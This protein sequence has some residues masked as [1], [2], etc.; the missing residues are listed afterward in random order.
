MCECSERLRAAERER[1][2]LR[3]EVE[4]LKAGRSGSEREVRSA[5]DAAHYAH[6]D[7]AQARREERERC[8]MACEAQAGEVRGARW[9]AAAIRALA[10][11]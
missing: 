5:Q 1:D 9:F 3:A 11:E 7:I 2:A 8:A 4:R 6:C 10:D